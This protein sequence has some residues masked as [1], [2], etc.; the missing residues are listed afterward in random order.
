MGSIETIV[1]HVINMIRHTPRNFPFF[2]SISTDQGKT[3]SE[4][5]RKNKKFK[6]ML[7]Q[8]FIMKH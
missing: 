8:T 2:N 6:E 5:L 7:Q 1:H 4:N 3:P